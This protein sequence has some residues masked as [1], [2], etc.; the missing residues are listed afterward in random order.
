MNREQLVILLDAARLVVPVQPRRI[1]L[2]NAY[3]HDM[4]GGQEDVRVLKGVAGSLHGDGQI[5]YGKVY[6]GVI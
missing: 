6:S 3:V 2:K 5:I 4:S 1:L